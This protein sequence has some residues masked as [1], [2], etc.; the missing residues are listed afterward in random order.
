[1]RTNKG[2]IIRSGAQQVIANII[3]KCELEAQNNSIRF[4]QLEK[5]KERQL[6][7]VLTS[8]STRELKMKREKK[9]KAH[10]AQEKNYVSVLK[11]KQITLVFK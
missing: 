6:T 5:F 4:T 1:M 9:G 7:Q 8:Q 11:Q 10:V 3:N 2:R